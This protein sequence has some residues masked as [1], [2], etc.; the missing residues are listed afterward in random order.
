MQLTRTC[1]SAYVSIKEWFKWRLCFQGGQQ[2][3]NV[4]LNKLSPRET[5]DQL[6]QRK[7]ISYNP[8]FARGAV[9]EI[10]ESIFQRMQDVSRYGGSNSYQRAT[11]GEDFGVD[12]LGSSMNYF[13]GHK[14]LPEMLAMGK[15]G[16]YVDMPP[17]PGNTLYAVTNTRPYV[18][19]YEAED[20]RSWAYQ[21]Q[22]NPNEFC[23]LLLRDYVYT[24]DAETGLP[25]GE[26]TR[27]RHFWLVNGQVWVQ[28]YD[29][30][31]VTIGQSGE[32]ETSDPIPLGISKIP[33]AVLD[34]KQ[35]LLADVANYQIAMM[36][37]ASSDLM[38]CLNNNFPM[39][40][41]QYDPKAI[42]EYLKKSNQD[43]PG[44]ANQA[45]GYQEIRTGLSQGRRY[46][47]NAT[48]PSFINPSSECLKASMDKQEQMKEEIRLLVRLALTNLQPRVS[49]AEAKG[50][51]ERSLESGL[52][53]LALEMEKAE[54]LISQFWA[55]YE[56]TDAASVKY[57]EKY[58]LRPDAD[59]R[60]EA[61]EIGK[62]IP[63]V[64]S[65]TFK[66]RMAKRI[67][68]IMLGARLSSDELN[69]I[70]SEI[71]ASPAIITD[72]Q[73]L[74]QHIE[75]GIVSLDTA[76]K[77]AG[78]PAGD[79]ETAKD[80][81][82]DRLARIAISQSQGAAAGANIGKEE[83]NTN[84]LKNPGSR[85]LK[86]ASS[87]PGESARREK[88]Q[89]RDKTG[90]DSLKSRIRGKSSKVPAGQDQKQISDVNNK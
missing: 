17:L 86:D 90:S 13:M 72:P 1:S 88:T 89:S 76:S 39:Y 84:E 61:D 23:S 78:Y 35:S 4:Y 47:L 40:V 56:G 16:V 87:N 27:F 81:H 14:I 29:N 77:I 38:F 59:R 41:E 70:Y 66:K 67:A 2:F 43:T 33:F 62:L 71:D 85:G 75:A 7:Q 63:T 82:A 51:D 46:P 20:I 12:L 65:P 31:G 55:M 53:A 80:D 74:V 22:G 8:S 11:K 34:I 54:K 69:K 32:Y 42:N 18:Y 15:V 21:D 48:A 19:L 6:N 49:S 50:L 24:Y 60:K 52:A 26:T 44:Q 5:N 73:V 79:V 37:M 45:S 30:E 68:E 9:Y 10:K 64:P 3:I 28:F 36:N 83:G 25:K 58:D 57:P